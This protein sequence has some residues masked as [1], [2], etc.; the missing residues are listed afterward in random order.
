MSVCAVDYW[1]CLI[2]WAYPIV[3]SQYHRYPPAWHPT[4]SLVAKVVQPISRLSG[5][6]RRKK[7]NGF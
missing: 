6:S 7:L 4:L 2:I 1:E 3:Q 5:G